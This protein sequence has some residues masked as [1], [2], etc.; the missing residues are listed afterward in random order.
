MVRR[1]VMVGVLIGAAS[2]GGPA[3]GRGAGDEPP[4]RGPRVAEAEAKAHA[5]GRT[6]VARDLDGSLRV[7]ECRPEEAA[8]ELLVLDDATRA[9]VRGVFERRAAAIDEITVN[10]LDLFNKLGTSAAAGRTLDQLSLGVELWRKTEPLRERG[11]LVKQVRAALPRDQGAVFA[12]LVD[13]YWEAVADDGARRSKADGKKQSRLGARIEGE[14]A[15]FGGEIE[16]SFRRQLV[17]GDLL[18]QFAF[19]GVDLRPEQAERLHGQF[20]ELWERTQGSPTQE[21]YLGLFM[22]AVSQLD[23]QQRAVFIANIARFKDGGLKRYASKPAADRAKPNMTK[24]PMTKS[25]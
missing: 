11:S 6:I 23:N 2:F 1:A 12:R 21:D 14:L 3:R 17:S 4:L 19:A 20:S 24:A 8:A 15:A 10:N 7:L 13:E 22:S 25:P 9:K 5:A 18:Y 16:R